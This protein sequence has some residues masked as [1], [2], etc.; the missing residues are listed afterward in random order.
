M[1]LKSLPVWKKFLAGVYG[2]GYTFSVYESILDTTT[3][4]PYFKN[5]ENKELMDYSV[6]SVIGFLK[7][8]YCGVVWPLPFLVKA[9]ETYQK[10]T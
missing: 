7:G 4:D 8:M 5:K 1:A 6:Y 2:T 10:S 3:R 9:H